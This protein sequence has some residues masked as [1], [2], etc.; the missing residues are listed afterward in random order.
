MKDGLTDLAKVQTEEFWKEFEADKESGLLFLDTNLAPLAADGMLYYLRNLGTDV[1]RFVELFDRFDLVDGQMIPEGER[2]VLFSKRFYE[3]RV[4]NRVAR[5]F[6]KINKE[7]ERFGATFTDSV[8]LKDLARRMPRQYPRIK[9]ELS[10]VD[11][12][13]LEAELRKLFPEEKGDLIA[14][15]SAFLTFDDDNFDDR[16]RFFYA[17]IAPMIRL[18]A[19]PIGGHVTARTVT[20]SG[21]LKAVKLKIWGTY[22]FKS[23]EDSEARRR[24]ESGRHAQLP[25]AVRRHDRRDQGRARVHPRGGR[26]D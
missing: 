3:R 7:R 24:A 26:R 12:P 17:T 10:A 11:G 18:Y 4:K 22:R 25:R 21:Y 13:I 5:D 14:L 16:Y 23:L 8:K 15:I 6:D 20:K 19:L 9:N 2:G 1:H